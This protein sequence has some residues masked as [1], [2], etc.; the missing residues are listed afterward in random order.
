MNQI[1]YAYRRFSEERF[2]LPSEEQV[3][4]LEE[5]LGVPLPDDYRQFVLDFNGGYFTEPKIDPPVEGCPSDR[6]TVL[7]GIGAT[8]PDDELGAE[9]HL[10][11]FTDNDPLQ[12]LPIG[13]TL[14]GNLLFLV[15]VPEPEERGRIGLKKASAQ[16]Y[17]ALATG[18]EEFFKLLREPQDG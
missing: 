4:E 8:L 5:R 11:L 1:E 15:T 3:A 17:F 7:H 2:P 9:A 6:L 16:D 18:I 13:Y 12:I 14:M 10:A